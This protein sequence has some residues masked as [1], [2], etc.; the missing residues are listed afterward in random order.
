MI[1]K[2]ICVFVV[3]TLWAGGTWGA[4]D[5][6]VR[7]DNGVGTSPYSTYATG[8]DVQTVLT[9]AR[10]YADDVTIVMHAGTH[11]WTGGAVIWN[12]QNRPLIIRAEKSTDTECPGGG[13][14]DLDR[15][16][17]VIQGVVGDGADQFFRFAKAYDLT[18]SDITLTGFSAVGPD[19]ALSISVVDDLL[20]ERCALLD[21]D[22][23]AVDESSAFQSDTGVSGSMT[24]A[25]NIFAY[26]DN[27]NAAGKGGALTIKNP[28]GG[29]NL[30]MYGNK[31]HHNTADEGGGAVSILGI[32]AG[33]SISIDGDIY[34]SNKQT[35]ASGAGGGGLSFGS[36][37]GLANPTISNSFFVYNEA[38][39][40]G[41]GG[42]KASGN[43]TDVANRYI[44]LNNSFIANTADADCANGNN[45]GSGLLVGETGTYVDI[46]STGDKFIGNVGCASSG[47]AAVR[48][49]KTSTGSQ[50]FTEGEFIGNVLTLDDGTALN[51]VA[52]LFQEEDSSSFVTKTLFSDN[53][54]ISGTAAGVLK[55]SNGAEGTVAFNL[56][57][58]N[59]SGQGAGIDFGGNDG[60]DA[61]G[62]NSICHHNIFDSNTSTAVANFIGGG[63]WQALSRH[64]VLAYHN[65]Y[66]NNTTAGTGGDA[67]NLIDTVSFGRAVSLKNEVFWDAEGTNIIWADSDIVTS[68]DYCD[69]R[70]GV[71]ATTNID[72]YGSDNFTL[73]VDPF[74]DAA[75]DDYRPTGAR[76]ADS[77]IG[78]DYDDSFD[79]NDTIWIYDTWDQDDETWQRGAYGYTNLTTTTGSSL[80]LPPGGKFGFY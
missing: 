14:S 54:G 12:N 21:N 4:I 65:S 73:T 18:I 68:M 69:I 26:N 39:G 78:A 34:L 7:T 20:I 8:G 60:A 11:T 61:D 47:G 30:I 80:S 2:A 66:Y 70:G 35:D 49:G 56:F 1:K 29:L 22:G 17:V 43:G 31:F 79:P 37:T 50:I 72:T 45:H 36:G 58:D 25:Y 64:A 48:G 27:S 44:L 16:D 51:G 63:A 33:D 28:S 5:M 67:I 62:Q 42:M 71:G 15:D 75:N 74:N 6:H 19:S 13:C 59:V 32:M 77:S 76:L 55:F 23:S 53:M 52:L 24:F 57:T 3:M 9:A 38:A 10:V 41:G 40:G 46:T